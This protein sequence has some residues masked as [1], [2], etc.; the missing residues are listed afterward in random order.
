MPI[1]KYLVECLDGRNL[2]TFF[3]AAEEFHVLKLHGGETYRLNGSNVA[4]YW[5]QWKN[6]TGHIAEDLTDICVVRSENSDMENFFRAG[7]YANAQTVSPT[8]W[9]GA[10]LEKFFAFTEKPLKTKLN[11]SLNGTIRVT[12]ESGKKFLIGTLNNPCP[13][14]SKPKSSR[15]AETK[16]VEA[17][18]VQPPRPKKTPATTE[19]ILRA[20]AE[21]GNKHLTKKG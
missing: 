17:A 4:D 2:K 13:P 11:A 1:Y 5:R 8:T 7:R 6:E 16:E 15:T 14:S 10:E 3:W 19:E 18:P 21:M 12:A 20:F 9:T